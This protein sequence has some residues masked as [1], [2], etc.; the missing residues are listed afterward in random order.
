MDINEAIKKA[1]TTE[2]RDFVEG[3]VEFDFGDFGIPIYL[4]DGDGGFA[5]INSIFTH[6]KGKRVRVTIEVIE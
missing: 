2:I 6:L 1:G 5:D 4:R 3:V